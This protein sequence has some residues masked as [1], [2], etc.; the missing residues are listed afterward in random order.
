[1]SADNFDPSSIRLMVHPHDREK[2][3]HIA[4]SYGCQSFMELVC[5]GMTLFNKF[6]KLTQ[7]PNFEAK[8]EQTHEAIRKVIAANN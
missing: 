5:L 4:R 1:M 8:M 7:D 2:A 6:H 3:E